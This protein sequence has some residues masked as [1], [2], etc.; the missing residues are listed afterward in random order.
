VA[1]QRQEDKKWDSSVATPHQEWQEERRNDK[2]KSKQIWRYFVK[3][4]KYKKG[5]KYTN[6]T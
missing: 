5:V 3:K 2:E 6:E 4:V 1:S